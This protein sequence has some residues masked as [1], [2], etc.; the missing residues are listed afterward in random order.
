M[1]KFNGFVTKDGKYFENEKDG[2]EHEKK[3]M[4]L[5]EIDEV[6]KIEGYPYKDRDEVIKIISGNYNQIVDVLKKHLDQ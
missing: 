6:L 3:V 1:K 2:L 5:K 4:L